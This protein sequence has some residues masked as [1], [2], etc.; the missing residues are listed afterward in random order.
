MT[1]TPGYEELFH[2]HE[3]NPILTAADWPYAVHSVFNPG[4]TRLADGTTLLLARVED[5]R[6]LSH[7]CAARSVNGVDGWI[8]DEQ[9]TLASDPA[10]HPEELWGIE[11]PRITF[12]D[13]LGKYAVAYTAFSEGGPGVALALTR[14]FREFE[15]CGLVMQPDDKDAC[16][17]P[18]RIDGNYALIHRPVHDQG[19]HIWI[20]YSPDLRNWGGHKVM[21]QARKGG[22]WD[23]NKVGLSPPLI[24]TPEGW[25]MIYHGV[26][27]TAAGALYRLGLAL[28][29]LERPEV[30]IARGDSWVF[31]P[32]A[33]YECH[34]DVGNVAFPCGYTIG[35][36]GDT[37]FLYYGAADTSIALATGSVRALL[38]W[39]AKS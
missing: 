34:G 25:L 4:A 10:K 24:A 22:W 28:F 18:R 14:D 16:L 19:A 5:R 6:G 23:A 3:K 12:V 27:N 9:P 8:I 26:R 11:D 39:L 36:D 1:P 29:D 7:L 20:S 30:C 2:R 15:R 21:L 35:A 13:E 17:L 37:I 33:S 32:E 38:A 31:G